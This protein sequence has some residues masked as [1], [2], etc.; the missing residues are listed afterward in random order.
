[1]STQ[2]GLFPISTLGPR[3]LRYQRDFI[4]PAIERELI[5]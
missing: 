5:A 3:G 1:M 4:S 2:L